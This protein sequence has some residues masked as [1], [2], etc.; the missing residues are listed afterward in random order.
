M[1]LRS[2][3]MRTLE[4]LFAPAEFAALPQRDLRQTVCVVFD[5]LRATSTIITAL[6]NGAKA[7][8]P[9]TDIAEALEQRRRQPDVLLAGERD[10]V[11]IRGHLT[12]EVDFDLGNS[13]REFSVAKVAGKTIVTTTTNG[14]RALL[15]CAYARRIFPCAFLNLR[16]TTAFVE[17]CVPDDLLLVCSGTGEHAALEDALAAGAMCD[18]LMEHSDDIQAGDSALMAREHFRRE[19]TDLAAA[20]SRAKNGRRLLANPHLRADVAWC[21]QQDVFVLVAEMDSNG[22]IRRTT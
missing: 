20:V 13:P 19:R 22:V 16:A 2:I 1:R 9:V 7:V 8:I 17:R 10:G 4:V 21:L 6:G 15:S 5:I 18:L 12:G 11:R 3:N 14:T